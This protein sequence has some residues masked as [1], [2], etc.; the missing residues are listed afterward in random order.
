MPEKNDKNKIERRFIPI[1]I[2]ELRISNDVKEPEIQGYA[3]VFNAWTEINGWFPFRE[4]IA[5]GTFIET[6]AND[7]IRSQF[8]HDPN[9]VLGTT[10]IKTL[11]LKEDDRGLYQKTKINPEDSDAMNVYAKVKRGDVRGQSFQFMVEEEEWHEE[12]GKMP[13]RT[14]LRVKLFDVGPVTFPAYE[15][16]DVSVAQRSFELYKGQSSGAAQ[17]GYE[18]E[19]IRAQGRRIELLKRKLTLIEYT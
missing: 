13:E 12:E 1:D 9:H 14:I 10:L 11:N 3:V 7:N 19:E 2:A 17:G 18:S 15:Q 6:I 5:P 16:T 4:R 8:N